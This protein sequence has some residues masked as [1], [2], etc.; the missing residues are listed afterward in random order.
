MSRNEWTIVRRV[1]LDVCGCGSGRASMLS[2][3]AGLKDADGHA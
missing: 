3:V 1:C 2:N